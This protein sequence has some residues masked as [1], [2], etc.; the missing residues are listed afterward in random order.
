MSWRGG[1]AKAVPK[2]SMARNSA[3]QPHRVNFMI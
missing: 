3:P 2:V 1:I